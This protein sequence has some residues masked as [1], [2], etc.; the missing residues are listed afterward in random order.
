MT[1]SGRRRR[2]KISSVIKPEEQKPVLPVEESS[3]EGRTNESRR[4][5]RRITSAESEEPKASVPAEES[6]NKT[7]REEVTHQVTSKGI[8]VMRRDLDEISSEL[9]EER[10]SA[11]LESDYWDETHSWGSD[12]EEESDE[13]WHF[14]GRYE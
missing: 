3:A 6:L 14:L 12:D 13:Y 10:N 5:S 7:E 9:R 1:D 2:R 11:L 4:R 8:L